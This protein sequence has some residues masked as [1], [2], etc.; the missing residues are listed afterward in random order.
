MISLLD[1]IEMLIEEAAEKE[2]IV[3]P[4]NE[5]VTIELVLTKDQLEQFYNLD[6]S[7]NYNYEIADNTILITYTNV[8]E[9][10]NSLTK[11]QGKLMTICE[12]SNVLTLII[13]YDILDYE[14]EDV[15][16]D[17]ASIT[18]S[19]DGIEYNLFLKIVVLNEDKRIGTIVEIIEI[20][21]N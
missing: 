12:L 19:K 14:S 10:F 20:E 3:F 9:T 18:V 2:G 5:S 8:D 17:N 13:G 7:D 4:S 1:K 16:I 6:L 15:F 11:L 21:Y